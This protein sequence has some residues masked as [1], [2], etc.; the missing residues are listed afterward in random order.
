MEKLSDLPNIG[1]ELEK[2][3][4]KVGIETPEYL[5]SE[6]SCNAFQRLRIVDSTTCINTLYS[7]EGAIQN[8]PWH[9]LDTPTR[10]KL[11]HFYNM[12]LLSE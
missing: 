8:I 11:K 12:L 4:V 5:K 9:K 3:L 7:L 6:G 2:R 10:Q 1:L